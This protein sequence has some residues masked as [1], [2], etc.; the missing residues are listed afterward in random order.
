MYVREEVPI[1]MAA[2]WES[3]RLDYIQRGMTFRELEQ[4]WG[5][6]SSTIRS[7]ASRDNWKKARE[8]VA[9]KVQQIETKKLATQK[10]KRIQRIGGMMDRYMDFLEKWLDTRDPETAE[11]QDVSAAANAL[12]TITQTDMMLT[13]TPTVAEQTNLDRLKLEQKRFDAEQ[14]E[15]QTAGAEK[16]NWIIE[17]E[18]EEEGDLLG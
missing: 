4:K 3:I 2:D 16:V 11:A 18:G 17:V 8:K 7:K 15:K 1:R 10:V 14:A 12:R 9:T 5:V 6:R 13:R